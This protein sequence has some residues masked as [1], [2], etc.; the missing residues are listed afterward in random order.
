MC[1]VPFCCWFGFVQ[2]VEEILQKMVRGDRYQLIVPPELGFGKVGRRATAGKPSLPA[3]AVLDVSQSSLHTVIVSSLLQPP[4]KMAIDDSE[5]LYLLMANLPTTTTLL[6]QRK[7][8]STTRS[9]NAIIFPVELH[10]P[11]LPLCPS[12]MRSS[13]RNFQEQSPN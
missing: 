2:G 5:K 8:S 11:L 9:H 3:N 1:P 6:K 4:E 12:S 13:C 7:T 10:F